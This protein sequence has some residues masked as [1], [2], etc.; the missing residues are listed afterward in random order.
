MYWWFLEWYHI[1]PPL[2]VCTNC[3]AAFVPSYFVCLYQPNTIWR[4]ISI[5]RSVTKLIYPWWE[6]AGHW[7]HLANDQKIWSI[8]KKWEIN[9]DSRYINI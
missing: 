1:I 9:V 7:P 6:T 3:K 2:Y 4:T 8:E 5:L